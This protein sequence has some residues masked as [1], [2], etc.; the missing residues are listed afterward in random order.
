[1]LLGAGNIVDLYQAAGDT[2]NITANL[3]SEFLQQLQLQAKTHFNKDLDLSP[4]ID[5]ANIVVDLLR[6]TRCT[7]LLTLLRQYSREG[8][9][10]VNT[11]DMQ[12]LQGEV[13][14]VMEVAV[15]DHYYWLTSVR[16]ERH[17]EEEKRVSGGGL[18]G[19]YRGEGLGGA[20]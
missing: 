5:A 6:V 11:V 13:V 18:G 8:L 1:M 19:G 17:G 16:D 3:T 7:A 9:F 20:C 14:R 2:A 12:Q 4:F 15:L 10:R